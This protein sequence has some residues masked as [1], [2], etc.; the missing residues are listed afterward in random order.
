MVT[1]A[2]AFR[3]L[4]MHDFLSL[5]GLIFTIGERF[6]PALRSLTC[7]SNIQLFNFN[8]RKNHEPTEKGYRHRYRKNKRG[9]VSRFSSG[10]QSLNLKKIANWMCR[11]LK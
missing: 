11:F 2:T 6:Q 8:S 7:G 3:S 4:N 10:A 5:N 9:V 1:N